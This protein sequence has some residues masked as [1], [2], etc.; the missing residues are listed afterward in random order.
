MYN[1]ITLY[2]AET[3]TTFKSTICVCV[4]SHFSRVQ[5]LVTPR[6]VAH[7]APLSIEFF[8]QEYWSGFPCPPPGDLPDP[9]IEPESLTSPA[10]A[11]GFFT[12]SAIWEAPNQLIVN[13]KN[14][15]QHKGKEHIKK[16]EG[17]RSSSA[18]NHTCG[19]R[20]DRLPPGI[21]MATVSPLHTDLYS[22]TYCQMTSNVTS[23]SLKATLQQIIKLRLSMN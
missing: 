11:S 22:P 12:P 15:H 4:L 17:E 8:R 16:R 5:L 9:G 6:T 13:L 10:L 1:W 7:Q 18:L 2:I 3:D 20:S 14:Y 19:R 23:L 21:N